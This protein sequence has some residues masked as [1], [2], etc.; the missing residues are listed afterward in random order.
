MAAIFF[1]HASQDDALASEIEAWLTHKGFD[2]IFLD[3]DSIRSGDKWAAALRRAGGSCRVVLSLVTPAWLASSECFGEFMAGWYAGRRMIPLICTAGAMLDDTQ[4]Q[5]LSRVLLEDQGVDIARAGAP[6]ALNLDAYPHISEPLTE[7]LRA[8]GALAKVG[9]DPSVFSIEDERDAEGNL[10][11]APFP[12]LESF[13]DTDSDAAIFYGRSSEIAQVLDDLREFRASGD[14]HAYGYAARAYVI[15]GASGSGKS[16]LLKAGVL[17]RLR[18]ERGWV[19]LRSFRPGSEPLLHFAEAL[20]KPIERQNLLQAPGAI[21]DRLLNSWR[22]A[23]SDADTARKELPKGLSPDELRVVSQEI[24]LVMLRQLRDQL[25]TEITPLKL[26]MDRPAATVLIAIDQGEELAQAVGNGADAFADYVRAALLQVLEGEP[27]YYAVVLTVRTDSFQEVQTSPRLEGLRTRLF[28]LRSLPMYRIAEAIEQPAS[29]YGVEIEPQLVE[30]LMED[31]GGKDALPLLAF[32][33]QR[34]WQQ[35]E[36]EKRI[37][38]VNYESV[39]KLLGLIEDAAERALRGFDPG[40]EQGPLSGKVSQ[41]RDT[42]G[43]RV[44]VPSLAQ[45]NERGGTIR[46]VANL[47][48][49]DDEAREI[50]RSFEKWRLVVTSGPSVE[51]THEAL[52]RAWPRFLRWLEPER[53]RLETLRAIESAASS[54][55]SNGRKADFISHSGRRLSLGQALMKADDF[56]KHIERNSTVADYLKA[57]S[58]VALGWRIA[59]WYGLFF[60]LLYFVILVGGL[61]AAYLTAQYALL[62]FI[63]GGAIVRLALGALG[64]SSAYL[65]ASFRQATIRSGFQSD[66]VMLCLTAIITISAVWADYV[67]V[68]QDLDIH[69]FAQKMGKLLGLESAGLDDRGVFALAA[70]GD[71]LNLLAVPPLS[72]A[73]LQF[74]ALAT[75]PFKYSFQ[76]ILGGQLVTPSYGVSTK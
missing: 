58:R 74:L 21:R 48:S 46:R 73:F 40:A 44:F 60:A 64:I 56:R 62:P 35:Y 43:Q 30:M 32:T 6:S 12:G 71:F 7:G 70:V 33:L 42:S 55:D 36:V 31:A 8:A 9:L 69:S 23:K 25:D 20:A 34:L 15:Q 11:K 52:F 10:L 3:H 65:A 39:G 18:R 13:G 41:R 57:A 59:N 38:K 14:R 76:K 47:E 28:D 67:F 45:V 17:P 63:L 37:R 29:R 66:V 19:A 24:D 27:A 61:L 16:S 54:W 75:I 53:A 50:L 2:D 72:W 1:S 51:V 5:R 49:F 26:K 4:E 68:Y 22:S